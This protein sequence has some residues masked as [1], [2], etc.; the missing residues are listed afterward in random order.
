[1]KKFVSFCLKRR[2]NIFFQKWNIT[3][4]ISVKIREIKCNKEILIKLVIIINDSV[5]SKP[6]I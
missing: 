4:E 2:N 5:R 3:I 1:M 6:Q